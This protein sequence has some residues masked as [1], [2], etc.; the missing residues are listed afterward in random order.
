MRARKGNPDAEDYF[1]ALRAVADIKIL[2]FGDE[3]PRWVT[4]HNV[5]DIDKKTS[6][7]NAPAKS[8]DIST[9]CDTQERGDSA[10][11]SI[12]GVPYGQG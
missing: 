4:R 7:T 2:A 10:H 11:G 1:K 12:E 6:A 5:Y 3:R 9:G 8:A